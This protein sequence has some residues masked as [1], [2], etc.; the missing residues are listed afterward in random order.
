MVQAGTY[1]LQVHSATRQFDACFS[2]DFK[3]GH[4]LTITTGESSNAIQI[5]EPK[6]GMALRKCGSYSVTFLVPASDVPV[7]IHIQDSDGNMVLEVH[8]GTNE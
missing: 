5:S 8:A 4:V 1:Y 2:G 3:A 6:A 7:D